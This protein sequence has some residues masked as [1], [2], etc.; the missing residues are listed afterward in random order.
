MQQTRAWL[1]GAAQRRAAA[2]AA[3]ATKGND[4]ETMPCLGKLRRIYDDIN[5]RDTSLRRLRARGGVGDAKK[6]HR[7]MAKALSRLT[8]RPLEQLQVASVDDTRNAMITVLKEQTGEPVATFQGMT[9]AEVLRKAQA[10]VL[11]RLGERV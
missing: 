6:N 10:I 7:L 2:A 1:E 3:A 8:G 9:N 11:K 5:E 4:V